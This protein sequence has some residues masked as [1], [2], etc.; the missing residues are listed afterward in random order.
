M[1]NGFCQ[2]KVARESDLSELNQLAKQD[3]HSVYA[4]THIIWKADEMAGYFSAGGRPMVLAWLST[5][6]MEARN[7]FTLINLVENQLA[8]NGAKGVIFPVQK[9]SPFYP[10]MD[11]LGFK[12]AGGYDLF[13]KDF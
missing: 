13:V 6:H 4:P 9:T 7:S 10:V 1:I 8:L 2:V 3:A 5:K 12:N 11:H